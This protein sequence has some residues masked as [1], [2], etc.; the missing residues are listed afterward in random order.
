LSTD[1]LPGSKLL[2]NPGALCNMLKRIAVEA[3]AITLKY[4]DGIEDME[5]MKKSDGSMVTN[6]DQEAERY[7]E[8]SLKALIPHIPMIG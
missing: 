2:A 8:K 3:G 7:I 4:F 1:S 5:V 6:A